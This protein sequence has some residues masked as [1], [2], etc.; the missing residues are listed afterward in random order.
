[1]VPFFLSGA[2]TANTRVSVGTYPKVI[3][4]FDAKRPED[5][6]ITTIDT[7][8]KWWQYSGLRLKSSSRERAENADACFDPEAQN[9]YP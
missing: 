2:F 1:M 7:T 5:K 6:G 4:L 8:R 9:E 3:L